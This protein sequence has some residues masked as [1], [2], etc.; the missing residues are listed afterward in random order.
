MT[1]EQLRAVIV[2]LGPAPFRYVK[3]R[4]AAEQVIGNR[5]AV[6]GIYGALRHARLIKTVGRD[7]AFNLYTV[8]GAK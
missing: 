7:G 2:W 8:E 1:D 3:L 6:G 5:H 4:D